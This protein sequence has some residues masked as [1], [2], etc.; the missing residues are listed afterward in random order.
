MKT[1]DENRIKTVFHNSHVDF[2][3]NRAT[4]FIAL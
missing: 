1:L 3:L 4:K 2:S